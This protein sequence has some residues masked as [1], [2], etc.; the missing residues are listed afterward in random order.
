MKKLAPPSCC[1]KRD[2]LLENSQSVSTEGG[3]EKF[4]DK[5]NTTEKCAWA[6][7]AGEKLLKEE[8]GGGKRWAEDAGAGSQGVED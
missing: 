4:T 8:V 7:H 6:G 3:H 1:D 5:K 2:F